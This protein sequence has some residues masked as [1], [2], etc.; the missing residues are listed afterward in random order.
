[1]KQ[2]ELLPYGYICWTN[3][4]PSDNAIDAYNRVQE[5]INAFMIERGYVSEELLDESHRQFVYMSKS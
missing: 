3:V 2:R 4:V 5:R 1:M